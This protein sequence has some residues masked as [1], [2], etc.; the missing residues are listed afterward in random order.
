MPQKILVV[1]DDA[2]LL[3]TTVSA[4]EQAG[5][6][7]ITAKDGAK[8]LHHWQ[9]DNPDLVLLDIRLPKVNGLEVCRQIHQESTTPVIIV[10]SSVDE[11][12]S[13]Q[14]FRR[15]A[16]DYISKPFS[17][18]ELIARIRAVLRRRS[19]GGTKKSSTLL[20]IGRFAIDVEA[21][22]VRN[23]DRSVYLTPHEFRIF[24]MLAINEGHIVPFDRLTEYVWGYNYDGHA[25]LKTHV[26]HIRSKLQMEDGKPGGIRVVPRVGYSLERSSS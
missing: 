7:T 15:G 2:E 3:A 11:E 12:T 17:I 19:I 1:D 8:A 26:S 10:T 13:T 24:Y 20:H 16:D 21:H 14:S 5:F 6:S 4:L 9:T 25:I 18:R 22:Q 23:G